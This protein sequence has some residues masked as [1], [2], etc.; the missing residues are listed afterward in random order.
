MLDTISWGVGLP[1]APSMTAF[2][3]MGTGFSEGIADDEMEGMI[4][5]LGFF[6]DKDDVFDAKNDVPEAT[7][8][9]EEIDGKMDM[10]P[11]KNL[12]IATNDTGAIVTIPKVIMSTPRDV[13]S[14]NFAT[15]VASSITTPALP[16]A[17]QLVSSSSSSLCSSNDKDSV[18]SVLEQQRKTILENEKIIEAQRIKLEGKNH[19]ANPSPVISPMIAPSKNSDEKNTRGT[20]RKAA[21]LS[22]TTTAND[23]NAYQK[24]KLTP[25][26][27]TKL[28]VADLGGLQSLRIHNK[29]HEDSKNLTP[30]E[31][32]IR[33]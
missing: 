32:Q 1:S 4:N 11:T 15:T 22:T 29:Q 10:S 6:Q 26:G 31:L 30:E 2:G 16:Q 19:S 9:L 20:K 27:A 24:W 5:D 12:P 7:R 23:K 33:R 8:S 14:L 21:S 13:R 25:D 17:P 18:Q 28:K 3:G